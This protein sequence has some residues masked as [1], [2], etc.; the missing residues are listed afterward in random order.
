M[1]C[2]VRLDDDLEELDII[3]SPPPSPTPL[4][5]VELPL[6][7]PFVGLNRRFVPRVRTRFTA[8]STTGL[9]LGGLDLSAGG[10]LCVADELIWPGNRLDLILTLDDDLI[11]N[12]R[13]RVLEIVA[14]HGQMA[15]RMCFEQIA[16]GAR[17]RI[18]TWM[19][20][21]WASPKS[22]A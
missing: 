4:A 2:Y 20:P 9:Q 7:E 11:V 8:E 19:M 12:A 1:A 16:P 10:M 6:A 3:Q 18:A 5:V 13:V 17:A 21:R 22:V 14:L 15:M